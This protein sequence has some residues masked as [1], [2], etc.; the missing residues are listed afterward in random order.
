MCLEIFIL[1]VTH[2]TDVILMHSCCISSSYTAPKLDTY[3]KSPIITNS[4]THT[5][6]PSDGLKFIENK[7]AVFHV[8]EMLMKYLMCHLENMM[9]VTAAG[10]SSADGSEG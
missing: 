8:I 9:N 5:L 6:T 2:L 10:F 3:K 1:C 7:A 4:L